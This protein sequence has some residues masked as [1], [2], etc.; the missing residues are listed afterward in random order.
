M[1]NPTTNRGAG[2]CLVGQTQ[3]GAY[4]AGN[5]A[6]VIISKY[7][8]VTHMKCLNKAINFKDTS[9]KI[10]YKALFLPSEVSSV[11]LFYCCLLII[12]V[13]IRRLESCQCWHARCGLFSKFQMTPLFWTPRLSCFLAFVHRVQL[14]SSYT[15]VSSAGA[16][17]RA[18]ISVFTCWEERWDQTRNKVAYT[19]QGLH[20]SRLSIE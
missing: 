12:L 1:I 6:H 20:R 19:E 9:H 16:S 8:L 18:I 15:L 13:R 17:R 3:K 14:V 11:C 5:R 10:S 7:S 4:F 2:P